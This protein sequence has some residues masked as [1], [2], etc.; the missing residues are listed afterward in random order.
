MSSNS[1]YRTPDEEKTP[2]EDETPITFKL[3]PFGVE[4]IPNQPRPF[5]MVESSKP[6]FPTLT[7]KEPIN[8]FPFYISTGTNFS[9]EQSNKL[10]VFSGI[11]LTYRENNGKS[12]IDLLNKL[13]L[14][15]QLVL[16]YI[17]GRNKEKKKIEELFLNNMFLDFWFIKLKSSY[18]YNTKTATGKVVE[19]YDKKWPGHKQVYQFLGAETCVKE[20]KTVVQRAPSF[21]EAKEY[22]NSVSRFKTFGGILPNKYHDMYNEGIRNRVGQQE[23]TYAVR[24]CANPLLHSLRNSH[25]KIR[26]NFET[27]LTKY[28]V[29]KHIGV[30]NLYGNY[31]NQTNLRKDTR[32]TGF[33]IKYKRILTFIL[34]NIYLFYNKYISIE[35]FSTNFN[36]IMGDTKFINTRGTDVLNDLF[37][38]ETELEKVYCDDDDFKLVIEEG[39]ILLHEKYN[40]E[41]INII[42]DSIKKNF[43]PEDFDKEFKKSKSKCPEFQKLYKKINP[44]LEKEEVENVELF[45][46]W[47]IYSVLN[48]IKYEKVKKNKFNDLLNRCEEIFDEI[49][50]T[51]GHLDIELAAK[52]EKGTDIL[53][54]IALPIYD[55]LKKCPTETVLGF[56]NLKKNK[57]STKKK[58]IKLKKKKT[59]N[60]KRKIPSKKKS[61]KQ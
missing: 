37:R 32:D 12:F 57:K 48:S 30:N 47:I 2:F 41:E 9:K 54:F 16:V 51:E 40:S 60:P 15:K 11:S 24:Y 45:I 38:I 25:L 28:Q 18:Q 56:R 34:I 61:K 17:Q 4:H 31:L 52:Y 58:N 50:S 19:S 13:P 35:I 21:E 20:I 14:L 7:S 55:I 36:T 5:Y 53:D 44:L 1:E 42:S 23:S 8:L 22:N 6:I 3:F 26:P 10:S 29:N 43:R 59:R 33:E 49:V 39:F 27:K 46:D